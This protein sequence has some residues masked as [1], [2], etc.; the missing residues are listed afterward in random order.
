MATGDPLIIGHKSEG[1]NV[2][3]LIARPEPFGGFSVFQAGQDSRGPFDGRSDRPLD[4]IHG[5]G[6]AQN[7]TFG[8]AGVVGFGARNAGEGTVG[9]GGKI[10]GMGVFGIGGPTHDEPVV[11]PILPAGP[12]VVGHSLLSQSGT[13]HTSPGVVG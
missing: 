4:G 7:D 10:G 3:W 12:G 2:T 1:S 11:G 8:G 9:L 5:V 13:A 6:S